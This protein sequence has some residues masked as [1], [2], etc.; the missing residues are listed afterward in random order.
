MSA[1]LVAASLGIAVVLGL[2][3]FTT[4]QDR[5]VSSTTAPDAKAPADT[6]KA[7]PASKAKTEKATFAG[8]CFWS[9]EAAFERIPG[10]KNVVSGFAGGGVPNPSY[11]L[12]GTGTTG[13]AESIQVEFDP[14]IVSYDTLL[15]YFW[16]AHDPTTLNS[17]GDDFGPQ[18]RSMIFYHSEEQRQAALK[19]YRELKARHAFRD[20]IVTELVPMTAFYPAEPYHQDYYRNHRDSS[21]S[22]IYIEPKLKKLHLAGKPARRSR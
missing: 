1:R 3:G 9:M 2:A 8:G 22:L 6:S 16:A 4:A 12:V 21:Y 5:P 17:Q 18:Y 11:E 14:S 20:P 13:H 19:S 15:K 10:V 7:P